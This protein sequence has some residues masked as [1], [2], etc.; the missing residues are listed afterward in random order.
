MKSKEFSYRACFWGMVGIIVI[1]ITLALSS[2][3]YQKYN[4]RSFR[5]TTKAQCRTY[6]DVDGHGKKYYYKQR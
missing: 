2:C 1:I 3:A 6:S 4:A 5:P